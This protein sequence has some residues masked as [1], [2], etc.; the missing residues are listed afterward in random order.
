MRIAGD[1]DVVYTLCSLGID[2][3]VYSLEHWILAG[4]V[5]FELLVVTL[6]KMIFVDV[7]SSGFDGISGFTIVQ[8]RTCIWTCKWNFIDRWRSLRQMEPLVNGLT[9][10]LIEPLSSGFL[11]LLKEL[12]T[13][14]A[15]FPSSLFSCISDLAPLSA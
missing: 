9:V 14:A 7:S 12:V 3:T 10:H 13:V 1:N 11:G 4:M 8:I 5:M 15:G 6:V 2:T